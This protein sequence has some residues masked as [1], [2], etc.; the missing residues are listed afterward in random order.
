MGVP[1]E[2]EHV[3]LGLAKKSRQAGPMLG[4]SILCE[5]GWNRNQQ[6]LEQQPCLWAGR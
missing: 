5:V 3:K 4:D 6:G 2:K 1:V